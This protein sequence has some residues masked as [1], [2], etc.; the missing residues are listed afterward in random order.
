MPQEYCADHAYH[1]YG[2]SGA[3]EGR[4]EAK[5]VD[6]V[7]YNGG[8]YAAGLHACEIVNTEYC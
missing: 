5:T 8:K 7:A 3:G 1:K 2:D 6:A 4:L